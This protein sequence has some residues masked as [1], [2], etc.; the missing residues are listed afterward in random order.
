MGLIQ[1]I[2][3]AG[4]KL[5]GQ[6]D[7]AQQPTSREKAADAANDALRATSLL[8]HVKA[9]GLEADDLQIEVDGTRCVVSGKVADQATKEKI[10]L[11]VGNTAGIGTVDDRLEVTGPEAVFYTVVSGDTLSK[12]AK[13]HYGDANK[14]NAIFEANRPMLEHPDKIFPGQVLRVPPLD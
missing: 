3:D 1:F 13:Q 4:A 7:A 10:A 2:K 11:A 9:L 12:I 6:D 8:R 14:Y 5:L